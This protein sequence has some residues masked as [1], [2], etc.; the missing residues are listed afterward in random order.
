MATARLEKPHWG[1][2]AVPFMNSTTS[3]LFTSAS[4][5]SFASLIGFS[6]RRC[7]FK[8]QR[9]KF[10]AHPATQGLVDKLVLPDAIQAREL[11]RNHPGGVMIAIASE[12]AN[13]NLGIG[14]CCSNE[15]LDIL[16]GHWHCC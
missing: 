8:L 3:L 12:I 11:L 14:N 7:G 13:L 5:R 1:N 10:A 2:S 15:R 16:C 6:C 4:M 9:M